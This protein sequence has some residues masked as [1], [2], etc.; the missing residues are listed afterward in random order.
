MRQ[1]IANSMLIPKD[2]LSHIKVDIVGCLTTSCSFNYLVVTTDEFS[3]Y[4]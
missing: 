3:R 2:C 1:D 4:P